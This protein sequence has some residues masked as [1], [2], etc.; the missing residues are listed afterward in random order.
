M[1]NGLAPNFGSFGGGQQFK[2]VGQET[3]GTLS[4]KEAR[5]LTGCAEMAG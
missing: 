2:L 3:H 5:I 4:A 1:Q